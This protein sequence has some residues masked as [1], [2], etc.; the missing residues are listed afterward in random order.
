MAP[1]RDA[2]RRMFRFKTARVTGADGTMTDYSRDDEVYIAGPN[3]V[4]DPDDVDQEMDE[5]QL[6]RAR[7]LD[8]RCPDPEH[9]AQVWLEIAWYWTP[10]EFAKG[11]L[12]DFNPRVCGSKEIIYVFGAKLDIINCASL[13]GHATVDKYRERDHLRQ[14]QIAEQDYY[15][16]TEYD[17]ENKTFKKKVVS[18]CLCKQQYIPDDEARMVFCPRSDCWTWYHTA[19]LERRDLHFRAPD[20]AQLESLWASTQDDSAF[21]QFAKELEFCWERSQSLDIKA[22]NQNDELSAVRTLA[23]RPCM[24]GG[25]YG[26]VG[27][28]GV[29]LRARYL[30]ELV[31]RNREELPLAWRD[32]VWGDGGA[33]EMP[34]W[35]HMTETGEEGEERTISWVCPNC[36]GPI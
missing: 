2:F 9:P 28:A 23:R 21:D 5:R 20:P 22:E 33:W 16:R 11:V 17:A 4:I 26:I 34:E 1:S 35:E 6:W 30:L 27:N 8:I 13:N 31:V 29:V 10:A 14:E 7:I 36:E 12:K 18:S 24:R 32:F 3:A 15:C 19:C 25:E